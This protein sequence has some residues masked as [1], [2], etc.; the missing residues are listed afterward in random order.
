MR[1]ESQAPIETVAASFG[2]AAASYFALLDDSE[3]GVNPYALGQSKAFG[4]TPDDSNANRLGHTADEP[5]VTGRG[6][7]REMQ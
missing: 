1:T 6:D 3:P 5:S 4:A 7:A 2:D